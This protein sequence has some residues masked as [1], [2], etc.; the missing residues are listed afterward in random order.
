MQSGRTIHHAIY[1]AKRP[2][3]TE[4]LVTKGK[5]EMHFVPGAMHTTMCSTKLESYALAT[6]DFESILTSY[7]AKPDT[8]VSSNERPGPSVLTM[9]AKANYTGAAQILSQDTANLAA[10]GWPTLSASLTVEGAE[11][12][13]ICASAEFRGACRTIM[14]AQNG[15]FAIGSARRLSGKL[16]FA[17]LATSGVRRVLQHPAMSK[18]NI[19]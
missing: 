6:A 1:T 11:P 12:W 9:Y 10:A 14:G 16:G 3:D 8:L 4:G 18:A 13:Q 5:M 15:T 7:D 2:S 19:R 17:N